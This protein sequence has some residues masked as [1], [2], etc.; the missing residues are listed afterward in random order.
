MGKG[1]ESQQA[2]QCTACDRE[3]AGFAGPMPAAAQRAGCIRLHAALLLEQV[4]APGCIP[5]SGAARGHLF[6]Q[7]NGAGL[8][9]RLDPAGDLAQQLWLGR[10]PAAVAVQAPPLGDCRVMRRGAGRWKTLQP[11]TDLMYMGVF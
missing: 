3:R 9:Q 2:M 5:A 10:R 8:V 7:G 4:Q 11:S 1:G 6:K